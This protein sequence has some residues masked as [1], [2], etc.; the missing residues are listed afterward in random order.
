MQ[1]GSGNQNRELLDEIKKLKGTDLADSVAS[2]EQ[3][4]VESYAKH[5]RASAY[6]AEKHW[7][8]TV[9]PW[10]NWLKFGLLL[11]STIFIFVCTTALI[12]IYLLEVRND[13]LAIRGLIAQFGEWALI[14]LAALFIEGK[15]KRD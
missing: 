1:L 3:L 14:V 8:E 13:A 4:D 11:L 9:G 15:V 6:K 10:V 2:A 12:S 5:S 7:K